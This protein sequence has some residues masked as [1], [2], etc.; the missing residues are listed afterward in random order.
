MKKY[1]NLF[2]LF[3]TLM[4][5]TAVFADDETAGDGASLGCC[6]CNIRHMNG[7]DYIY[8]IYDRTNFLESDEVHY[9]TTI[10]A[11]R[12]C[13]AAMRAFDVCQ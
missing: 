10:E 2:L 4:V 3:F 6:H 9:S 12:S 5:S 11:L 8:L 13:K 7:E 1:I